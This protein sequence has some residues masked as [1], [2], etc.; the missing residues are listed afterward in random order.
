MFFWFIIFIDI[1]F[2]VNFYSKFIKKVGIILRSFLWFFVGC[3]RFYIIVIKNEKEDGC[4]IKLFLKFG[5]CL[6]NVMGIVFDY[7]RS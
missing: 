4:D 6:R 3:F 5:F 7:R 1:F 2:F